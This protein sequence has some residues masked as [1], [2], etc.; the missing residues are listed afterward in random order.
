[1]GKTSVKP[2]VSDEKLEMIRRMK[3]KKF[4]DHEIAALVGLSGRKYGIYRQCLVYLG[5]ANTK[6]G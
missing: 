2:D 5:Y 1:M 6:E 3:E 4:Q